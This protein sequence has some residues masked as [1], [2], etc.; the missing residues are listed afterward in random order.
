MERTF[1]VCAKRPV[2]EQPVISEILNKYNKEVLHAARSMLDEK[3]IPF[4][5]ESECLT[6]SCETN[7]KACD[8]R[9]NIS[10]QIQQLTMD[11]YPKLKG[12]KMNNPNWTAFCSK[13][14]DEAAPKP[15]K[16]GGKHRSVT[17]SLEKESFEPAV[18]K[19][20]EE[21]AKLTIRYK[22]NQALTVFF[23]A[24]A[25]LFAGID[26][27]TTKETE[28]ETI[29]KITFMNNKILKLFKNKLRNMDYEDEHFKY[30]DMSLITQAEE[31]VKI[32]F[33]KINNQSKM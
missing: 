26:L 14:Y 33:K 21:D 13:V 28:E 27:F 8:L 30:E 20:K 16:A 3:N 29:H 32:I 17:V 23:H 15:F 6:I 18:K 25:K 9:D 22:R 1:K 4:K 5:Q 31:K 7:E 11:T 10:E 12:S 24:N 19:A 2:R